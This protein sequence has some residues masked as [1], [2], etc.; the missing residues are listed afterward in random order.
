M[1]R[2]EV[3]STCKPFRGEF[4]RIQRNAL[5][6]WARLGPGCGV[7]I[8][9]DEAGV[10]E[11]CEELGFRQVAEVERA[12]DG[13]PRLD[14]M[15]D[16]AERVCDGDLIALVN[17]DII[18][19]GDLVR[20]AA[21]VRRRWSEFLMVVRRWNM[22]VET[23]LAFE[24]GWEERLRASA[25]VRGWREPVFGGVDVFV[26][27][28]GALR[29]VPPYAIGR[30]RWDSGLIYHA[31]RARMAVVDATGVVFCVH[32]VHGYGHH[33]AGRAGV[34]RG[35]EALNNERLLGGE[36]RVCTALNATHVLDARGLRPRREVNPL[37]LLRKWAAAPG[38]YP[39]LRPL[40]P[41]V[42]SLAPVWRR[43]LKATL[44]ARGELGSAEPSERG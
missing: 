25:R 39:W 23:E 33:V 41:L 44:G 4:E 20:A 11:I 36:E 34:F 29:G 22:W 10:A 42:R 12:A 2:L 21:E 18:L 35:R 14:A 43:L 38:L 17:A 24:P 7:T 32:Q 15:L 31:R 9:G 27:P 30:G 19:T 8:F 5:R 37:L 28:K 40:A 26:F 16:A 13:A 1:T 6:S 3:V